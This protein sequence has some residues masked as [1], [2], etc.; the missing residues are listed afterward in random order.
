MLVFRT[1]GGGVGFAQAGPAVKM[2]QGN[3][4]S[5]FSI[6]RPRQG[7]YATRSPDILRL[8]YLSQL[9]GAKP[10]SLPADE[11]SDKMELRLGWKGFKPS[12]GRETG[13]SDSVFRTV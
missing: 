11:G 5:V 10:H 7:P 3:I 13:Q 6:W 8:F 2:A 9:T 12:T 4:S 1:W